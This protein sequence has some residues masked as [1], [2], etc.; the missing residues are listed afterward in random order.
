M[1]TNLITSVQNE[2]KMN[3]NKLSYDF[4]QNLVLEGKVEHFQ[5][6]PGMRVCVITLESGHE[7]LGKAQVLDAAN[8][9]E[10]IGKDVALEDAMNGVWQNVGAIAKVVM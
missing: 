3:G 4:I 6:T 1:A 5:L 7:I 10:K 8:D 2:L 9:D